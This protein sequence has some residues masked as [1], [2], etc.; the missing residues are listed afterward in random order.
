MPEEN[1]FRQWALVEIFG[2]QK[3][4][5]LVSEQVIAGQGFVRI[6]VPDAGEQPGYTKFYGP[7]AIYSITPCEEVIARAF[8]MKNITV[9]VQS[10]ELPAPARDSLQRSFFESEDE[11]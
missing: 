8:C 10:Y 4:A 11:E 7:S 3:I 9:P 2:H 5:G 6:D 1:T